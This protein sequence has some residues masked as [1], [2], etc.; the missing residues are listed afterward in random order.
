MQKPR[1]KTKPARARSV[2]KACDRRAFSS[3]SMQWRGTASIRKAAA[4]LNI[5]SSALNRHILDNLISE[6]RCSSVCRAG[7]APLPPAS[8]FS[9]SRASP[10]PTSRRW[11]RK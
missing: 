5:A 10:S 4:A 7:S 11:N 6:R 3:M 2:G 8:C 9:H 1:A